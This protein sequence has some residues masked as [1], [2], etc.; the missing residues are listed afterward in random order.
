MP[1]K[2]PMRQCLGCREMKPKKELIRVVKS[3][4]GDH[5]NRMRA[6]YKSRHDVLIESL[7]PFHGMCRIFGEHAGVHLLL[8][9]EEDAREEELIS[10]A[11]E[12]GVRV[13]GLS[14]Y[15][16]CKGRAARPTILLGYANLSEGQIRDAVRILEECWK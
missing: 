11:K 15:R 10:K 8:A 4:E 13:Y 12:Q 16:I 5:L 7:R 6:L 3:P 2:I 1:K 14:D 9:F